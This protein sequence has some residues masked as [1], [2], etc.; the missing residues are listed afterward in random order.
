[1]PRFVILLHELPA[2]ADRR[3]HWDLMLEAD[4]VLRTW[5]LAE[6]PALGRSIAAEPLADHRLAYLTYEGEVSGNRGRVTRW[7]SG[8][9]E[10]LAEAAD[11]LEIRLA[12]GRLAGVAVLSQQAFRVDAAS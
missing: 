9:Y 12:G 1:M 3:T 11:R 5:A 8:E 7:D 2:G 4:G 10:V 6:E